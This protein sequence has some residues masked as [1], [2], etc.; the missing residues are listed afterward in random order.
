MA[1]SKVDR[2][3]SWLIGSMCTIALFVSIT[4]LI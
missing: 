3:G 1:T 2:V 4:A